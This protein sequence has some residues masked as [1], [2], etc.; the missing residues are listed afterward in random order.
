M[1]CFTRIWIIYDLLYLCMLVLWQNESQ[2]LVY[3]LKSLSNTVD[4]YVVFITK[5]IIFFQNFIFYLSIRIKKQK[6]ITMSL[7]ETH[8]VIIIYS[9][10]FCTTTGGKSILRNV[11]VWK[12]AICDVHWNRNYLLRKKIVLHCYLCEMFRN[13]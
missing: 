2:L 7:K 6:I 11:F 1:S 4:G 13:T 9:F 3:F 5:P 8:A 12:P 10:P